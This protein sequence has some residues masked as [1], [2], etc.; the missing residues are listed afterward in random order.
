MCIFLEPE[1]QNANKTSSEVL[2]TG[3]Q[4]SAEVQRAVLGSA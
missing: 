3:S 1:I 2:A 4:N